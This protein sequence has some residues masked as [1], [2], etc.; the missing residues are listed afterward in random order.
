MDNDS[1]LSFKENKVSQRLCG[2][3]NFTVD[4]MLAIFKAIVDENK[5]PHPQDIYTQ[6]WCWVSP[7][8]LKVY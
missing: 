3:R 2:P 6:V 4:R 5:L 8:K 1:Q 7:T